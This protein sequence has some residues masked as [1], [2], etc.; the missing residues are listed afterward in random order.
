MDTD[1]KVKLVSRTNEH[2]SLLHSPRVSL[3]CCQVSRDGEVFEVSLPAAKMSQL[4]VETL[5]EDEDDE[6]MPEVDLPN[7]HSTVLK[8]VVEYVEHYQTEAMTAIQTPL[9]S[10]KMEDLVQ[11]W[12]CEFL[13]VERTLLFD[14]VAASNYM[15]IKP[16]LDLSCLGV[17][18][19]IKGKPAAELREMFNIS[20]PTPME[21]SSK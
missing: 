21:T 1:K 8:K 14:L 6:D 17:A 4:V 13:K 9:K 18:I 20:D 16:L 19:L 2:V 12:Y 11:P 7:V 15:N 5:P 10:S 3:N